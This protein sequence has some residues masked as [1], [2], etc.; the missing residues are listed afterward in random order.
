MK[1]TSTQRPAP[2]RVE[3]T[4]LGQGGSTELHALLRFGDGVGACRNWI[5]QFE[6]GGK[7]P[8]PLLHRLEDFLDRGVARTP[9][10]VVAAVVLGFSV[11]E[12]DARDSGVM[13]LEKLD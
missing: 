9:C 11:L 7:L 5:L 6:R 12:M 8:R 3:R 2:A 4:F 13:L 1:S 10:D